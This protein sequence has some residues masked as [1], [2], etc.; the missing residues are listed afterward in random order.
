LL[1]TS[2]FYYLY[3]LFAV[4]DN[5]LVESSSGIYFYVARHG[6]L[7]TASN[8]VIRFNKERL[9]IGGAMNLSTGVFTA[10]KAGIYQFSFSL[11][12]EGYSNL[13]DIFWIYF[14]LN[15]N[16]MGTSIVSPG[17]MTAHATAQFILKL[18][19]GDRVDLWKP[20]SGAVGKCIGTTEPCNHFTGWLLEENF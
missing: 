4:L 20:S 8:G 10:T 3:V 18:K 6:D 9:N 17:I 19:K 5:R 13:M 14:R 7:P 2:F 11:A 15:G 16:K 1:I 12:K